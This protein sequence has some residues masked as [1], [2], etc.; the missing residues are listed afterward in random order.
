MLEWTQMAQEA[1]TESASAELDRVFRKLESYWM[2]ESS[3]PFSNA[4]LDL[5]YDPIGMGSM[6]DADISGGFRDTCGDWLEVYLKLENGRISKASFLCDGCGASVACGSATVQL[7]AGKTFGEAEG[8]TAESIAEFLGGL[9]ESA[10]H[11]AEDWVH[12][13]RDA[14]SRASR[15]Q[16]SGGSP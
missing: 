16:G 4:A 10:R 7:A 6:E 13:L 3:G 1:P 5:A 15:H 11:A 2:G 8:I 9:P 12:A 14:L